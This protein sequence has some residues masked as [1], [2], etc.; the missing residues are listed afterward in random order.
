MD[1]QI[2]GTESENLL[3]AGAYAALVFKTF[4]ANSDSMVTFKVGL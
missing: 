4:D 1:V 2:H 3:A